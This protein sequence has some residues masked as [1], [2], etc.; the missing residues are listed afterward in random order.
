MTRYI[1]YSL[2]PSDRDDFDEDNVESPLVYRPSVSTEKVEKSNLLEQQKPIFFNKQKENKIK[3]PEELES[4]YVIYQKIKDDDLKALECFDIEFYLSKSQNDSSVGINKKRW[5]VLAEYSAHVFKFYTHMMYKLYC[6]SP[7]CYSR[8]PRYLRDCVSE[9]DIDMLAQNVS[10]CENKLLCTLGEK[11]NSITIDEIFQMHPR[12]L[13]LRH[14][15]SKAW[16]LYSD[17]KRKNNFKSLIKVNE[18]HFDTNIDEEIVT[19]C[20]IQNKAKYNFEKYFE[21]IF[22]VDG[23]LYNNFKSPIYMYKRDQAYTAYN[24]I[25]KDCNGYNFYENNQ[26]ISQ[27]K[28][29]VKSINAQQAIRVY[30]KYAEMMYVLKTLISKKHQ[31][32]SPNTILATFFEDERFMDNPKEKDLFEKAIDFLNTLQIDLNGA[33]VGSKRERDWQKLIADFK[34]L[35][36]FYKIYHDRSVEENKKLEQCLKEMNIKFD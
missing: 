12:L 8:A 18:T 27:I 7:L 15:G 19:L 4:I 25:L 23:V 26:Y 34:E 35:L 20:G 36:E 3:I 1:D 31:V 30:D 14:C 2:P 21:K 29:Q 17:F 10:K 32:E 28:N 16:M 24:D 9:D 13:K 33:P 22:T 5:Q 6:S 11:R